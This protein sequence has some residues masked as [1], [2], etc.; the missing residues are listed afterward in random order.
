MRI[1]LLAAGLV[2]AFALAST[3]ALSDEPQA[4]IT[5][6]KIVPASWSDSEI[7]I[8]NLGH[9]TLLINFLGV[10]VI[11]DPALLDR[12]GLSVG[13]LLTIGPQRLID[14]VLTP[15]DLPKVDLV[16]VTHAHMDH[17][18]LPSLATMPRDA[19]VV[20]SDACASLIRPVGF[21]DVRELQ[22]GES[23]TVRG[24]RVTALGATH[25]GKRWPW[26]RT[27][28]YNSYLLEKGGRRVFVGCDS[29]YTELFNAI[30][31][32]PPEV[33]AFSVGAYDP[34]I[35]NHA[36]PEQ[37]WEMFQ[38]THSEYLIPIHWGTFRLSREP[39]NEPVERLVRVAG[40]ES[41]RIVMRQIGAAWTVPPPMRTA[42]AAGR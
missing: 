22:W 33:A 31:G 17:L 23:I 12:V 21:H 7:T 36:N 27:Y 28:G 2:L 20:T 19:M 38:Q 4:M 6:E 25:W 11:T 14:P 5:S 3:Y 10:R 29:A 35:W 39:M 26:G 30:G 41:N 8:A 37:V 32:R 24:L 18:D 1:G 40:D 34:W 15:A 13:G 9:A 16:L 42:S